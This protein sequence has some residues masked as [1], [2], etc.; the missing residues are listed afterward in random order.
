MVTAFAFLCVHVCI[1]IWFYNSL[2]K[3]LK[4][5]SKVPLF[6]EEVMEVTSAAVCG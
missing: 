6:S 1:R 5:Y 4:Y 2:K 3:Y